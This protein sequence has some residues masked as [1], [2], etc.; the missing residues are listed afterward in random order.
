MKSALPDTPG[1]SWKSLRQDV[2]VSGPTPVAVRRRVL[3]RGRW[4]I[5]FSLLVIFGT[6]FGIGLWKLG[7]EPAKLGSLGAPSVIERI[8]FDTDGVIEHAWLRERLGLSRGVSLLEVDIFAVRARLLE[9][10]Q[11]KD[12]L[13]RRLFPDRLHIVLS[14]RKPV[15]RAIMGRGEERETLLVAADGTVFRGSGFPEAEV[16]R[17]PFL[18][19]VTLRASSAGFE[20]ITRIDPVVRI[21]ETARRHYPAFFRTIRVIDLSRLDDDPAMPHSAIMVRSTAVRE[22]LFAPDG[23]EQQLERLRSILGIFEEHSLAESHRID[24]RFRDSVPVQVSQRTP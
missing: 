6:G 14:E 4:V 16:R 3:R 1:Q 7:Q 11:V 13:V 17:L 2:S 5:G 8:T 22:V 18:T 24:L 23:I 20:P 19:G 9:E 10:P 21:V 15:F 12:A